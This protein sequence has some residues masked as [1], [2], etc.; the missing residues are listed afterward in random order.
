MITPNLKSHLYNYFRSRGMRDYRNNWMKGD[1][2]YCGKKDKFGI[3]LAINRSNC[4]VCGGKL[5]PFYLVQELEDLPNKGETLKF[6]NS[7]EGLVYYE[8]KLKNEIP[9]HI[10][11]ELPEGFMLIN[12]GTNQLAKS[13][14]NYIRSRGFDPD[15]MAY[16]GWGYGTIGKYRGYIIIPIYFNGKLLYF[17]SRRFLGHGP[18][19]LNIS[20]DE[21]PIGKNLVMYNHEA[22][23]IYDKIRLVESV[24]NAET[25]G[26]N[27]VALNGKSVSSYQLSQLIKADATH[28]TILFD[29]DAWI[30][31][32]YLCLKLAPYK[33]VKPVY[34]EDSRD[35]N[36]LGK[37]KVLRKI[38]KNRYL[39]YN[40]VL[41][42]K[43]DYEESVLAYN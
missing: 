19:F 41:K 24:M 34:F 21:V 22:L 15:E 35:V 38:F 18:K 29:Q 26:D 28:F 1:C 37:Q 43:H 17:T 25:L 4:F 31:A 2:P 33:W 27:A 30:H 16:K 36:D 13:A 9:D 32:L 6:L 5:K 20:L 40:E 8:K 39:S 11:V 42:L 3:N 10:S 23:F 12:L 7:Y 14:R